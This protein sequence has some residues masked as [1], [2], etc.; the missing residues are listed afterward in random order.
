MSIKIM[1][2]VW[3]E[4]PRGQST[5][6]RE[7]AADLITIGPDNIVRDHMGLPLSRSHVHDIISAL[8]TTYWDMTP[9]QLEQDYADRLSEL[10]PSYVEQFGGKDLS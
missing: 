8:H 7:H 6:T 10:G 4:S 1:S 5:M 2:R 9:G 3:D